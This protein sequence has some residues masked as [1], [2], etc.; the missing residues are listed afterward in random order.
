MCFIADVNNCAPAI[1][2]MVQTMLEVWPETAPK[3]PTLK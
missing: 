3:F 2:A 1:A